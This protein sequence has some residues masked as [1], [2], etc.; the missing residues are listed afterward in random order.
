MNRHRVGIREAALII[1]VIFVAGL[2]AFEY[3]FSNSVTTDKRV[4]FQEMIGLG[5]IFVCCVAYFG[6][7]RLVEQEKEIARRI[8]AESRAHELANTD[9]LTGLANRRQFEKALKE[10][11]ASLP[12]AGRVHAVLALDL[13]N[14]KKINDAYGHPVGDDVLV[15][16][17]QRLSAAM[18]EGDLLARLG[19]DE[20]AVIARHLASAETAAGIANRIIKAFE[21]PIQAGAMQR[22]VGTGIGIALI[23]NDGTNA[24]EI[25]RKA[26]IAL[27]RA[28]IGKQSSTRFFEEEMDRHSRE[29]DS[30][31]RDLAVAIESGVVCPWYQPIVDLQT[32]QVIAFEALARWTHPT[33][34]DIPPERFI[35]IAEDCGL[36]HQLSDH[37]LHR[38]CTDALDWPDSVMLSFNISPAQLK[39]RTLGLRILSILGKTGISPRRLEIELTESAIVRDLESA[40]VVLSALR[41]AG[42]R[43]AL[44]DFGTGYSS[45]YHLRN[46]KFDA[47][48]IDRSFVGNMGTEDES[49]AIVRALTGLGHGL[50][51]VIT[52]EGIEQSDQ[53]DTLLKQGCERG[54]GFLF[55][56]AVPAQQTRRLLNQTGS[57]NP[58]SV[59]ERGHPQVRTPRSRSSR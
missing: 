23:P 52:A 33:L 24:E 40:K 47:I 3:D 32:Q 6:W 5:I 13:N 15:S 1:F 42:V 7:R 11:T 9:A 46:F 14:F 26:D 17:S 18:R 48:K 50:G 56:R 41:E 58:V 10:T 54:Q 39:E 12:G 30:L 2:I 4:D 22:Q 20:F 31:E 16:A 49:A 45:L 55:S 35:P 43:V 57:Q 51:L 37:L 34:G 27:Y 38:A 21:S 53:R 44:D 29:R 36:I 25:L 28:K 8:A 59:I 19:G